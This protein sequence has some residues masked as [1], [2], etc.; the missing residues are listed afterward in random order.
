MNFWVRREKSD[1]KG[2]KFTGGQSHLCYEHNPHHY[3][4][5]DTSLPTLSRVI[6]FDH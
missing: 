4:E 3:E 2:K 6:K 5:D 1:K